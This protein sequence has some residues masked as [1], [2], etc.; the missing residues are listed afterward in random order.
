L[1]P[2]LADPFGSLSHGAVVWLDDNPILQQS[3][4]SFSNPQ[5]P[6]AQFENQPAGSDPENNT[7]NKK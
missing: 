7:Y 5:Q 1:S 2:P 4:Q 3:Q 6:A